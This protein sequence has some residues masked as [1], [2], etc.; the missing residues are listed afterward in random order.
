LKRKQR[1]GLTDG[2]VKLFL[3]AGFFATCGVA[4][5]GAL[6]GYL[7][8]GFE[9]GTEQLLSFGPI[10][11]AQGFSEMA[12]RPF[13]LSLASPIACSLPDVLSN[14]LFGGDRMSHLCHSCF[15]LI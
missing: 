13:D 10:A 15:K 5:H 7:V 11:L 8:N 6:G 1:S 9:G 14:P 12:Y 3:Q 4:M 2:R